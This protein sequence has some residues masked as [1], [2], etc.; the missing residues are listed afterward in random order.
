MKRKI[1]LLDLCCKA[2][3]ASK[4]Y[5][6]GANDL[7][8]EIEI[9][10][11]DIEM[12]PNYPFTFIQADAVNYL[13]KYHHRFTHIH[14]SPP[15]QQYT[16]STAQR[17][18]QGKVYP[19]NLAE[20][21]ALMIQIGKP[22]VIENVPQA[23]IAKDL[24]LRGDMFG[25]KVLRKRHF[26]LINWFMMKPGLPTKRG[27]VKAGDY[28]SVFG[29]SNLQVGCKRLK[30]FEDKTI[31][32]SWKHAMNCPWMKTDRELAEAI[33]PEYTRYISH[34]FFTVL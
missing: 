15:C 12:Q 30:G 4:G 8:L 6:L 19:D 7:G 2:G 11:I 23:P 24:V 13:T 16:N 18:M 25:L 14:A 3:G 22:G 31:L 1:R 32:E 27:T 20:I 21:K 33:P 5:H 28:V 26:E 29:N 10:G 34:N 17:R 9:V